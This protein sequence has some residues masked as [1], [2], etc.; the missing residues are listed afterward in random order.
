MD[1]HKIDFLKEQHRLHIVRRQPSNFLKKFFIIALLAVAGLGTTLSLNI[2]TGGETSTANTKSFSLFSTLR[3]LISSNDYKLQGEENDRVNFL[4]LGVGGAGH[5]GPQLT[6]TIIFASLRPSDKSVGMMS[7]P[8]DLTVPVPG[9]GWRK[10]NAVNALAE[11][12]EKGSGPAAVSDVIKPIFNQ[13]VNYYVKVDF[14]GF[15]D[16]IDEL[17]GLDLYVENPF[18]DYEYPIDGMEEADC[19]G[20]L[21]AAEAA[22]E[23]SETETGLAETVEPAAPID[24]SCRFEVLSFQEGWTHMDGTTALKYVRSRH[25]SNGEASDFA[26]SRRQQN[27]LLSL[28]EKIL[29][30]NTL[31]S[32]TK[33]SAILSTLG[34][35]IQTNISLGEL[36][37]LGT[38]YIDID[39]EK[40]V[41]QVLDTSEG[42]PLYATSMNGAY[43]ILPK[44]DDWTPLQQLAANIFS[45]TA[46]TDSFAGATTTPYFASIEI[47]NGTTVAGLAFQISQILASQ[48]FDVTKIGNAEERGFTHTVIY[49]LT[50]GQKADE[51]KSLQETLSAEV[52]MS[53]TGWV[54]SSEVVPKEISVTDDSY[55][56]K[57]TVDN[58]DFLIILGEDS[59]GLVRR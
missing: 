18:T 7:I 20:S 59:S 41:N 24:Y 12:N 38:E 5:D 50:D 40:I 35:H 6:D 17:G 27:L 23:I 48:G 3:D 52:V 1:Q 29:S 55:S 54:F 11:A 30:L 26:R 25:G 14:D 31:S 42:G 51:L 36:I 16:L 47:Q 22:A 13:D 58:I 15:A 43:V 45:V 56:Q 2:E 10:I 33:I 34:E 4:L 44:N 37:T 32:P 57:T 39:R 19:D 46:A 9:E 28:K 8:R 53:T 49:D 21:A